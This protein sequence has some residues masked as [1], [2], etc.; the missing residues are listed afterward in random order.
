MLYK[1]YRKEEFRNL[2]SNVRLSNK[3][4]SMIRILH[5]SGYIEDHKKYIV[6]KKPMPFL[7]RVKKS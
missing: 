6:I 1:T 5:R 4:T 2:L 7:E 3:D